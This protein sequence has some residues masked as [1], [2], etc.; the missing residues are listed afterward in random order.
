M[1]MRMMMK[2]TAQK[3][4][5]NL[6]MY[7]SPA[8]ASIHEVMEGLEAAGAIDKATLKK[9]DQSCL[10]P[11]RSLSPAEIR[12][13]RERAGVSRKV[14]ARYLNVSSGVVSKWE[15]GEKTPA[16]A[17]LKLLTLVEKKGLEAVA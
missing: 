17:S 2:T 1:M 8:A 15:C 4:T 14:L 11:V 6:K 12:A 3:K 5:K 7:R 13:I 16:G 10:T 9:F